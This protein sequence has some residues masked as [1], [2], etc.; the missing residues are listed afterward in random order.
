MAQ[1]IN[2]LSPTHF[3]EKQQ[4]AFQRVLQVT[5]WG[6][7]KVDAPISTRAKNQEAGNL[8][9]F[10]LQVTRQELNCTNAEAITLLLNGLRGMAGK[11]QPQERAAYQR[12]EA[13]VER[14]SKAILGLAGIQCQKA[15]VVR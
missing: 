7:D 12:V 9:T 8:V 4:R 3:T 13:E 15:M 14:F 1:S 11:V 2:F 5:L 10:A 6:L